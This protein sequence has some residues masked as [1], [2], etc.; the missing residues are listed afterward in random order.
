MTGTVPSVQDDRDAP[1]AS[2]LAD[3]RLDRD[4]AEVGRSRFADAARAAARVARVAANAVAEV[5]LT[6]A[7]YR[8]L[9]FVDGVERPATEV[10]QLLG[11]SPSTLTSVIDGLNER[12]LVRRGSGPI[13]WWSVCRSSRSR[14]SWE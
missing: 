5:E 1:P 9:V 12:G 8:T 6:L 13:P 14:G 7:Q 4:P 10:A 11:V 3:G 2:G